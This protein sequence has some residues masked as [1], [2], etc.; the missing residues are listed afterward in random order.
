MYDVI[1]FGSATCDIFLKLA[2]ASFRILGDKAFKGGKGL[3]FSLG[4]KQLVDDLEVF[5][6]GGGTNAAATFALQGLKTAYFGKIGDDVMG[7]IVLQDFKKFK[8]ASNFLKTDNSRKTALSV[9]LSGKRDR[10]ILLYKGACHFLEKKDIPFKDIKKTKWFYIAP[11][12][13]KSADL[14]GELVRFARENKI[15]VA[16]NLSSQH[17]KLGK[18]A[19]KPILAQIDVL[20]LNR[21]EASLLADVPK[22]KELET[23]KELRYLCPGII[24]VTKGSGG[25]VVCDD[26]RIFRVEA[27]KVNVVEKT[28]AGDAFGSGFVAGLFQTN[29]V[30]YAMQLALANSESCIQKI[31]AKNGL[32]KMAKIGTSEHKITKSHL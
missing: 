12:Y 3:C 21:T 18:H 17:L 9:V 7:S 31:G 20:L 24:V 27:A 25:A 23:L 29:D 28:G 16:L 19:L 15:E 10:T 32:L 26:L 13:G 14:L 4:S 11:L 22:E 2:R 1:T 8:I 30:G 6:G 5:S